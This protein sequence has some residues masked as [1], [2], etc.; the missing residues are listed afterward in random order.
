MC[1]I[2]GVLSSSGWSDRLDSALTSMRKVLHHRGPDDSGQWI[3][4]SA[5]VGLAHTRLSILDLS[6]AGHQPM[7]TP[8]GRYQIV[9]NGEIYNFRELRS[10][11]EQ[12]GAL[13][14]SH[15]DTEV[16]LHL[17][18]CHGAAMV[19]LLR[20]MFAFCIW[21]N[22]E[23][24]AFLARDPFGIKPLYYADINGQFLFA[25]ELQALRHCG[26]VPNTVNTEAVMQFL[27][28]GSVPEPMTLLQSV[29][30]LEAGHMLT[31]HGGEFTT[32]SYWSLDFSAVD[33]EP[34]AAG[35]ARAALLDSLHA[36]F[37]SDVPVGVFLSGGIDST[38]LVALA[39]E[40]GMQQLATF[41]IGVDSATLDESSVARRTA[42][43]FG[44]S[45]HELRLTSK[46]G[47]SAFEAFLKHM[48]QPSIDGFNS[49]TVSSF[50]QS[51]GMKVVLSGLGG[52]EL[53]GGYPSFQQVPKL[54]RFS[55]SLHRLPGLSA[56]LGAVAERWAPQ[57]RFRRLGGYLRQPPSLLGAWRTYRG[58]FSRAEAQQIANRLLGVTSGNK[59]GSALDDVSGNLSAYLEQ[60]PD[61]ADAVSVLELQCYMRNQLL[62]DSD[63]MSMAHGL[64]L[65]VPFV[66][67][68]LFESLARIP[69]SQRIQAGKK[70]LLEAIPEIPEWVANQPK[71]GFTFPFEQW[72]EASWGTAF[73]EVTRSLPNA[74]ATWYQ[75]WAVFML[76]RWLADSK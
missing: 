41:S 64:E 66:D 10:D 70:L 24:C 28:M 52:D 14:K 57:S 16:L 55:R 46:V 44:T 15:S 36:H 45:H 13:F 50:A 8:D 21:D 59:V 9:F 20:G 33:R 67:R 54:S 25:S 43:H 27:E 12:A 29:S 34:N 58:V 11:L 74:N 37:V 7:A 26:L 32:E 4:P 30:M 42:E 18:A 72:L 68:V 6:P 39:R 3:D 23:H 73:R 49:F 65:R 5:G 61:E 63:V 71:R 38:A 62:R 40:L 75:R 47:E 22:A 69:A 76:D 60:L 53:F 17:Y 2:S 31:W 35:L 1:S 48:D 19:R 56:S 51:Q